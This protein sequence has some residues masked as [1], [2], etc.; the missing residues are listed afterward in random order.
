MKFI[1]GDRI[2]NGQLTMDDYLLSIKPRSHFYLVVVVSKH[3]SPSHFSFAIADN[4][5]GFFF[6]GCVS[7]A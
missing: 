6:V 1:N 3:R 5:E 2:F 7:A 4:F